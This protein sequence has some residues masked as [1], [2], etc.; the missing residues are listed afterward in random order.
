MFLQYGLLI[1]FNS[2][3]SLA[4]AYIRLVCLLKCFIYKSEEKHDCS[5]LLP[6]FVAYVLSW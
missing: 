3:L 5:L 1:R 4:P 2:H 6:G